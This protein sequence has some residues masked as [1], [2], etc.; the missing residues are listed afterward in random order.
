MSQNGIFQASGLLEA[1]LPIQRTQKSLDF[2]GKWVIPVV[3]A[4][5]CTALRMS[6]LVGRGSTGPLIQQDKQPR[7]TLHL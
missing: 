4:M 7:G 2:P 3:G 5:V 1:E 6:R